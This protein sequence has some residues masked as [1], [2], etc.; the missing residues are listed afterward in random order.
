M[1]PLLFLLHDD[2]CQQFP[3]CMKA[4]PWLSFDTGHPAATKPLQQRWSRKKQMCVV[5]AGRWLGEG[6]AVKTEF[7]E[8]T[9]SLADSG[10]SGFRGSLRGERFQS[11]SF[12]FTRMWD[13]NLFP[14]VPLNTYMLDSLLQFSFS[15]SLPCD[16]RSNWP[17]VFL[18]KE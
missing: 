7:W 5:K 17:K 1:F 15:Q 6:G 18:N 8:E 11:G 12:F 10:E 14:Q 13:A 9:S 4:N 16:V 2:T 3:Q